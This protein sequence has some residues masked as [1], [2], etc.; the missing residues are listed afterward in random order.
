MAIY[1]TKYQKAHL[2]CG[3]KIYFHF[4]ENLRLH[5]KTHF[6]KTTALCSNPI[7]D[8]LFVVS[9]FLDL[10]TGKKYSECRRFMSAIAVNVHKKS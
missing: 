5:Q 3:D 6:A 7:A 8:G 1:N 2:Y 9:A 4:R 10:P